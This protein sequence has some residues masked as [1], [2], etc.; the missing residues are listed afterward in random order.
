MKRIHESLRQVFQRHRIVFWYDAARE[1]EKAYEAFADESVRK[2]TVVGTELGAKVAIHRAPDARFLVYV[3]S[4]R[5]PDADNWLL[6][7]LLQ[8]HEYKADRASLALQ[9]VGLPYELRPVVEAHVGFFDSTKRV[10]ALRGLLIPD[11]EPASL[12]RK[13]MAV[14]AG[15]ESGEMIPV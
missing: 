3:P 10:D 15:A 5:P 9:D 13:L 12:R 2:L 7:F 4:P 1:W 8:G 11:E 6:D 14:T